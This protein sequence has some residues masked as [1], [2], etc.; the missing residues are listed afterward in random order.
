MNLFS[1]RDPSRFLP[2]SLDSSDLCTPALSIHMP[3]VRH[4][5]ARVFEAI[6]DEACWRPHVKTTKLPEVWQLLLDAGVDRFKCSTTREMSLLLELVPDIDVLLAHHPSPFALRRLGELAEAYPAARISAL[7]E[8]E[9]AVAALPGTVGAF[10]DINPGMNRSGIPMREGE[11]IE[12]VSLACGDRWRGLHFYEGHIRDGEEEARRERAHAAFDALLEIDANLGGASEMVTSGTPTFLHAL[13][14]ARLVGTMRHTVSP[15]TVVFHDAISERL[16]EIARLGLEPAAAVLAHV[17]SHP[18][19]QV[20]TVNA[21]HKS[22][23][24]DSGDP[25]CMVLGWPQTVPLHPSEEHM[26]VQVLDDQVPPIGELMT[27]IPEHVCPTVNL[28][29]YAILCEDSSATVVPIDAAGHEA[30]LAD[31][32][33]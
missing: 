27:L 24:A 9:R 3:S 20:A 15:G 10:V 12:M 28:S 22:V 30:P 23:S 14:H 1:D 17:V 21:G 33:V 11:R 7:V 13:S 2:S 6:G 32:S 29:R 5:I 19:N 4:N 31:A 16:P 8:S 26:P 18:T 25:C